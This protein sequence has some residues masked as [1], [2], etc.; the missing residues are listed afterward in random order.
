MPA[1]NYGTAQSQSVLM[2]QKV[3]KMIDHVQNLDRRLQKRFSTIKGDTIG[4]QAYR[5]EMQ[6]ESGGITGLVQLDGGNYFQGSGPQYAQAIIAPV[7]ILH[8][9]TATKLAMMISR[10]A[11]T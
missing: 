11:T 2:L 1:P 3:N 6:T 8:S 7:S 9:V 4:L 5:Q 10:A